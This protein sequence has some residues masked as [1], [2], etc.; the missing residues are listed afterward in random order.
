MQLGA[1]VLLCSLAVSLEAAPEDLRRFFVGRSGAALALDLKSG[2][3]V[4]TW[5]EARANALPLRPGSVLKPFTLA[6]FIEAGLYRPTLKAEEALAYSSNEFFD[7]LISR[8]DPSELERGY[9]RFGLNYRAPTLTLRDLSQATR[10]LVM[11]HRED[12]LRPV[13][14]GLEEAV[15][16][17]TARLA[18]VGSTTVAGKTGTT[19]TSAVFFGFAPASNPRY[20]V[21]VHLDSGSGGGDAAPF[22]ARIFNHLF[23]SAT[24][25]FDPASV[26]LRLFWQN[27]P[28]TLNL[29][30]GKYPAGTLIDTGLS[31]L[32]APGPLQVEKK[33]QHYEITALVPLED[34]VTA[35]LHGEA[36][37][38]RHAA[39]RQAM[40]IAAR[41]YATRFRHRHSEEGFDFC[42]TTH[43]Q[44]ARFLFE[45]RAELREAAELTSSELLWYEG[46]PA[47][48]YY[49]ADSGGWLE[50]AGDEPYLKMR[51]DPWWQDTLQAHWSWATTIPKL[52]EAL[53]LSV[54]RPV[55]AIRERE[56]SGRV[57]TLDVFGHPAEAAS[58]RNLVGRSL[59]WEKLPSRL[60]EVHVKGQSIVFEGKGRGHGIGLAQTSA[61]RMAAAGKSHPEIL[62]EYYP[63]TRIGIS[64][65]GMRWQTLQGERAR[66][67][68]TNPAQDRKWLALLEK[69]LPI[70]EAKLGMRV[71]PELRVY[72]SREAFR[73][74]TGIVAP[75]HGATRGRHIKVPPN[76]ALL[77]LRHELLHALLES[78]TKAKHPDWLREGLVQALLQEKSTDADRAAA[79]ISKDGLKKVL[80]DWQLANSPF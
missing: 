40:A 46:K 63:G 78:N 66:L 38:S 55:F 4:G 2:V 34:Y 21:L 19:S 48:A 14:A 74:A 57:R 65:N 51:P 20:L 58:F 43:C 75:V 29:K 27:P 60:F 26:R 25:P 61:E 69:E 73:D 28:Q 42:D 76:P 22:A 16:Y 71:A 68:S 1:L 72:P 70:W 17:G 56:R 47:A 44:D 37:G 36:G 8:M 9:A 11:R 45:E 53:H 39:A 35:V 79:L 12:R 50:A 15:A 10:R 49:H 18:T 77:T 62:A 54:I 41:T 6:A 67:Y 59:G 33:N 5:N 3:V 24:A 80:Q 64:A 32:L 52:A 31:K 23:Q 13:F 30:P 7:Q